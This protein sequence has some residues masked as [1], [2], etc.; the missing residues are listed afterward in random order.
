MDDLPQL[1][2]WVLFAAISISF[3]FN[4]F[5]RGGFK[6]G[7]F[8]ARIVETVGEVSGSGSSIVKTTV[9]VHKLERDAEHLVGLELVGKSFSSYEMYPVVL[10]KAEAKKLAL[11]L[12]QTIAK[13]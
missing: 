9:K 6:A 8:N 12:E 1:L 5:R 10:T 7:M 3:V 13:T 2:F 4:A 11:I